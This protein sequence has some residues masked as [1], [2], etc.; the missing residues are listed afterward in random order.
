MKLSVVLRRVGLAAACAT[1]LLTGC[2]G[3]DSSAP[4][5]IDAGSANA[6]SRWNE[7]ASTTINQANATTGTP[8]EINSNYAFDLATLHVAMY[9]AVVAIAGGYTPFTVTP[10]ATTGGASQDAAAIA[11]A[12]GVLKGLFPARTATYQPTYDS[13]LAGI[14]NGSAKTLGVAVGAEVAAGVL[15]SRANDGRNT[16]LAPFVAGTAPG[17]F[18]GPAI[19]GRTSPFVRPFAL[20]SAAQFRA[21][22]PQALGSATYAADLNETKTLG[23]AVGSTRT[24]EQSTTALFHTEA[25]PLFWSRNLRGFTMTDRSLADQARLAALMWV[26]H[27]DATIACFESKYFYLAWRP[28]S[29]INLADTDGN[30]DTTAD[31]AWTSFQPTPPHPEYPAAHS[32]AGGASME[33]VR[34]FFGTPDVTFDFASNASV[35][36]HHYTGTD[37]LIDDITIGRIAG[38]MHF[39]SSIADGAALGRNVAQ[40]VVQNKFQPR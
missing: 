1:V 2:G 22:G 34:A 17:Q 21:P 14:P 23:A 13:M 28:F 30:A 8:E 27:A 5:T 37:A 32:C 10:T 9:D 35:T 20:T 31:P 11:A 3:G 12:Y 40:W 24:A 26:S 6:V 16:A 7:I 39:R 29:A 25:P 36:S 15:A 38:G 4:I 33:A 18:R 19:V